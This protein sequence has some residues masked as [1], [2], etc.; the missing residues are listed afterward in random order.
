MVEKDCWRRRCIWMCIWICLIDV[1]R[2]IGYWQH[3]KIWQTLQCI[4]VNH[5]G[6][7]NQKT[8]L[9]GHLGLNFMVENN[10]S[11]DSKVDGENGFDE[12]GLDVTDT[13]FHYNKKGDFVSIFQ[14]S[15]AMARWRQL[16]ILERAWRNSTTSPQM[17]KVNG[18][19][20]RFPN[21]QL[22]ELKISAAPFFAPSSK[23]SVNKLKVSAAPF[24]APSSTQ[25]IPQSV[26][27]L[28]SNHLAPKGNVVQS[29][30]FSNS[31][32]TFVQH[33]QSSVVLVV[34][35]HL[36]STLPPGGR[37]ESDKH[38]GQFLDQI[39]N[40][41]NSK[42]NYWGVLNLWSYSRESMSSSHIR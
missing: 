8:S 17:T 42:K 23:S 21:A 40:Q 41:Y 4:P 11:F 5:S 30:R 18:D 31:N 7:E 13:P 9:Q 10:N 25:I 1:A 33:L 29:G 19:G 34:P 6:C 28:P 12:N 37:F 39:L 35:P 36:S 38:R 24:F 22:T 20:N 27:Q 16:K 14:S 2:Y 32:P 15:F 3:N 26:N